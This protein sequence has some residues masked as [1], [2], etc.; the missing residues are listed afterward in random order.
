MKTV[1]NT[2]TRK[3]GSVGGTAKN[4]KIIQ[5]GKDEAIAM[6]DKH[7]KV[8]QTD[9]GEAHGDD[10][11]EDSILQFSQVV[12]LTQPMLRVLQVIFLSFLS[13]PSFFEP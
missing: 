3:E 8:A 4:Q 10:E 11:V 9:D 7:N 2:S 5:S 12:G 13:F 1:G 6:D